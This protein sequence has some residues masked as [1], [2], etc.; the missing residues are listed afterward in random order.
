MTAST[1]F[2]LA[3]TPIPNELELAGKKAYEPYVRKFPLLAT[4]IRNISE[5]S[6]EVTRGIVAGLIVAANKQNPIGDFNSLGS[7]D[8]WLEAMSSVDTM[9]DK[10]PKMFQ[11]AAKQI[12]PAFAA[13]DPQDFKAGVAVAWMTVFDMIT[14]SA[15]VGIN[16]EP[17]DTDD[18]ADYDDDGESLFGDEPETVTAE[19]V[20]TESGGESQ[21]KT[22]M[23]V[24]DLKQMILTGKIPAVTIGLV[25]ET[26]VV[27]STVVSDTPI[28]NVLTIA[29][30]MEAAFG[31]QAQLVSI[32]ENPAL[33]I[34]L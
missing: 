6:D 32:D 19:K 25:G 12:H 10:R 15:N 20:A 22:Q 24:T 30:A 28:D 23:S 14:K 1:R 13:V 5:E 2:Y 31:G 8:S 27:A 4:M 16:D 33:C 17:V 29:R 7:Q 34:V 18:A 11:G 26:T 21:D 9:R 3:G